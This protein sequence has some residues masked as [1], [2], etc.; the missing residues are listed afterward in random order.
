MEDLVKTNVLIS[1]SFRLMG[2]TTLLVEKRFNL[3]RRWVYRC[4]VF[5]KEQW[6]QIM[7][8]DRIE[9]MWGLLWCGDENGWPFR[10]TVVCGCLLAVVSRTVQLNCQHGELTTV[11]SQR[12]TAWWTDHSPVTELDSMVNWPQ[13]SHRAGQQ[14]ELT[15]V[16]TDLTVCGYQTCYV[17][18]CCGRFRLV[19]NFVKVLYALFYWQWKCPFL[20]YYHVF[21]VMTASKQISLLRQ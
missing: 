14:C 15:T 19:C 3:H 10:N 18:A 20:S 17:N 13:S 2:E 21:V 12:W 8:V 7:F 4:W 6:I 9:N 16:Q 5:G 11:Q 1:S